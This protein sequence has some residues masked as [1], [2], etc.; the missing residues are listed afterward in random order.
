MIAPS[1]T[2]SAYCLDYYLPDRIEIQ[3][4]SASETLRAL[5]QL[6][7]FFR[8]P[9][10]L[11]EM[12]KAILMDWLRSLRD[13][14]AAPG[15]L[16]SKR[17]RVLAVWRHAAEAGFCGLVP[18]IRRFCE[19]DRVPIVW[20]VE[21]FGRILAV[22]RSLT[23]KWRGVP[24]SLAWQICFGMIW[25]SGCRLGEL[26]RA[27]L[28]D[29][30]L[31]SGHWLAPAENRKG[32][33]RDRLYTLHPDTVGLIRSSLLHGRPRDLVFPWPYC[34]RRI[35][36]HL[37]SILDQ[38]NLPT[39]PRRG[40]HCIRRTVESYAAAA[41]G[42]QWAADAIGHSVEVARRSYISPAITGEHRLIDAIPR[43]V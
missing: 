40:F 39:G 32:R 10:I 41:R 43:P 25:D 16:N 28:A 33:R 15:T 18:K 3:P 24:V 30:D 1:L 38:A 13:A 19:P 2:L 4:G 17:G 34:R 12:S 36:A 6:D 23:G 14:G 20:R 9:V 37:R 26:L 31:D 21:E 8:R 11:C 7:A 42:D 22:C 29:L 27:R 5:A 35:W